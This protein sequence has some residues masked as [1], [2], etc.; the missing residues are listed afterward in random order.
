MLSMMMTTMTSMTLTTKWWWTCLPL[1]VTTFIF[2]SY[3]YA[4]VTRGC[5]HYSFGLSVRLHLALLLK[6]LLFI[7]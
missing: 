3:F 6:E 2:L 4:S 5:R 1:K 7:T